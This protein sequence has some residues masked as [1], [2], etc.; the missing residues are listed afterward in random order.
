MEN[1]PNPTVEIHSSNKLEMKISNLEEEVIT[2]RSENTNNKK[3]IGYQKTTINDQAKTIKDQ[4]DMIV[5]LQ[6][7]LK[8]VEGKKDTVFLHPEIMA[9]NSDATKSRN[10]NSTTETTTEDPNRTFQLEREETDSN[11]TNNELNS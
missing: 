8:E 9:L 7:K 11:A 3:L 5:A 4:A 10:N 1:E 2:L 6:N